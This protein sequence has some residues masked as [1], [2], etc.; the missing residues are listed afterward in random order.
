MLFRVLTVLVLAA[1]CGGRTGFQPLERSPVE[2]ATGCDDHF[3]HVWSQSFGWGAGDHLW[4]GPLVVNPHGNA[5]L[6][7]AFKGTLDL[8]GGPLHADPIPRAAFLAKFDASSSHLWSKRLSEQ[9]LEA[10]FGTK[11]GF[12]AK[13]R[14]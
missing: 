12:L 9:E 10:P 1:G 14:P 3:K 4:G 6:A 11:N 7:G 13:F 8:G 5:L 2:S